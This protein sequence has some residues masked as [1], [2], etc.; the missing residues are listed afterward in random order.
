L[1]KISPLQEPHR[2][3]SEVARQS[4]EKGPEFGEHVKGPQD[5]VIMLVGHANKVESG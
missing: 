4:A 3:T 2:A 1:T 5:L